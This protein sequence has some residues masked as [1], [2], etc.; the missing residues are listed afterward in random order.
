MRL[1]FC[2][3]LAPDV[4]LKPMSEI[5]DKV[6]EMRC[7]NTFNPCAKINAIDDS[8]WYRHCPELCYGSRHILTVRIAPGIASDDIDI[9]RDV[10]SRGSCACVHISDLSIAELNFS[11]FTDQSIT[12]H[13]I[14][15]V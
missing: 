5:M 2:F 13:D 11:S 10:I 4:L 6:S 7:I 15:Y 8:V 1:Y 9:L 3:I 12:Q 14:M